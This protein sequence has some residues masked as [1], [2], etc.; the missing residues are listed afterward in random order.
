MVMREPR[1]GEALFVLHESGND[2]DR[3]TPTR[4]GINHDEDPR[5]IVGA[6]VTTCDSSVDCLRHED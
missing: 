1:I 4:K 3:H 5:D 6:L 2:H